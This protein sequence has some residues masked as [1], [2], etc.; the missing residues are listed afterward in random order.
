VLNFRPLFPKYAKIT[1][2]YFPQEK[3]RGP[4]LKN[5]VL[6]LDFHSNIFKHIFSKFKHFLS[7]FQ[8]SNQIQGLLSTVLH[9]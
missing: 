7:T 2:N 5:G 9:F 1:H 4:L 3:G 6:A 8:E